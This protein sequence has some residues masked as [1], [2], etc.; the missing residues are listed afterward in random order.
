MTTP[1]TSQAAFNLIKP[2]LDFKASCAV[3]GWSGTTQGLTMAGPPWRVTVTI[4]AS[5]VGSG[6][7]IWMVTNKITPANALAKKLSA[8]C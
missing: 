8:G 7:A 5:K 4:K 2:L 6:K 1:K 3:N